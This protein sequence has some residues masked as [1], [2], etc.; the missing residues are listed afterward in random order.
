MTPQHL[1]V[2][3]GVALAA[4]APAIPDTALFLAGC[5]GIGAMIGQLLAFALGTRHPNVR[6]D[7]VAAAVGLGGL[8]AGLFTLAVGALS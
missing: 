2:A 3:A 1:T 8:L 4:A 6:G 5:Y 7:R